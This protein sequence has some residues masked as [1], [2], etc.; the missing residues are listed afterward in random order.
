MSP[1]PIRYPLPTLLALMMLVG[2]GWWGRDWLN[3]LGTTVSAGVDRL[4]SGPPVPASSEPKRWAGPIPRKVLLLRENVSAT[5]KPDGSPV[6]TIRQRIFA[7]VF[8]VWPLQGEPTHY[9]IGNNGRPIGWV[10]AAD[11]LPWNTR[12]VLIARSKQPISLP[13]SASELDEPSPT[14]ILITNPTP[15]IDW[16]EDAVRLVIWAERAPWQRS[17]RTVWVPRAEIPETAWGV[18]LS[19]FELLEL[20]KRWGR[21]DDQETAQAL[22]VGRLVGGSALSETE[23]EAIQA[24]L[25]SFA[26]RSRHVNPVGNQNGQRPADPVADRLGRINDQWQADAS[27]SGL[28]FQ[29]IPLQAL[30]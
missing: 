28:E 19:R 1:P 15:I 17:A 13:E 24:R 21:S 11:V 7:E 6:E 8:D 18:W 20:L 30:P 16:T 10:S 27:W 2:L 26:V 9:R 22:W 25:P 3:A 5:D 23:I 29:A 12:L 4:V 14:S